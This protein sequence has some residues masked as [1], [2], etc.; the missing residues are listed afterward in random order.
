MYLQEGNIEFFKELEQL[1]EESG[2]L[3][4]GKAIAR[5]MKGEKFN[6]EWIGTMLEIKNEKNSSLRQE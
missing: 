1:R 5:I 3:K 2:E 6:N 4:L